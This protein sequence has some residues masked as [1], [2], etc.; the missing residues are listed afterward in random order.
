MC[1]PW[2]T[3]RPGAAPIPGKLNCNT[4]GAG[5][6]THTV[7]GAMAGELKV[8]IKAVHYKG[9]AQGQID[10]IAGRTQVSAATLLSSIPQVR[11]GRLRPIGTLANERSTQLPDLR[12]SHEQGYNIDFP[13][14]IG[15]FAPP[16]TRQ[17]II[18]R[19]NAEFVRRYPSP[20]SSR[21]WMP[22]AASP[23]PAAPRNPARSLPAN[24]PTGSAS[25]RTMSHWM[26]KL[27][28]NVLPQGGRPHRTGALCVKNY[29]RDTT[30]QCVGA[31]HQRIC[32]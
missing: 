11:Q 5:S 31:P 24:W 4:S 10:L 2:P 26:N 25:S 29:R 32:T 19:L 18:R 12:T 13:S 7:C 15:L 9:V 8:P 3:C 20:M 21:P 22:R 1:T 28:P 6:I 14:W 17:D 27:S 30:A 16:G 23:S